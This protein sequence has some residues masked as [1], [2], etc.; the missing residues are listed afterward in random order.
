MINVGSFLG[1]HKS[2]RK[3]TR[4][5]FDYQHP[6]LEQ[7][8]DGIT[9]PNPIG[10]AAGFDKNAQLTQ[11]LPHIGFGFVEVGSITADK[12][13]GNAKPRLWRLPEQQSLRV[14]YGLKNNGAESLAHK[15]EHLSQRHPIGIS[16]AATNSP[17]TVSTE[18]AI[19]DYLATYKRFKTI[20]DYDTINISCPNTYGGEPFLDTERLTRLLSAVNEVRGNKPI[21]L[22]LTPN[23]T[24]KELDAL[25]TVAAEHN[26]NGVICSNLNKKHNFGKG[27]LSG[28][29]VT[30]EAIAHLHY[31]TE[32]FP[33]LTRI[34]CGGIFTPDDAIERIEAGAHLLQLITGMIYQG[35]Q[36]IGEMN[37][38]LAEHW[39][40]RK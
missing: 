5:L 36:L 6:I 31:I 30:K 16:I 21:Y 7:T 39:N 13:R 27:G 9:F 2:T 32:N 3:L 18:E 20:G 4:V 33:H 23:L 28:K 29:A 12:C 38:A 40:A 24:L 11:I 17:K 8:I 19:K 10:L 26:M 35:P 1:E 25:V 37:K 15:L 34:S 22:K 14:Y